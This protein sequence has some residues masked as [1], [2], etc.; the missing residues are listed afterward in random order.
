M[1]GIQKWAIWLVVTATVVAVSYLW[2]DRGQDLTV[3]VIKKINPQ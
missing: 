3:D 1:S 2:L